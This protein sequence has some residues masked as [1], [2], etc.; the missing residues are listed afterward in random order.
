MTA[1]Q[2]AENVN[3]ILKLPLLTDGLCGTGGVI[4][5]QCEDFVVE[6]IPLYQPCGEGTHI[7]IL[8]EKRGLTT[9]EAAGRLAKA[10][11]RAARDV[12]FAGLKDARSVARQWFSIEHVEPERLRNL[13]I[14]NPRILQIERHRNKLKLGHLAGNRFMIKIRRLDLPLEKAR[15]LAKEVLSILERRGTPNYFGPQRF[16]ST[17]GNHLLGKAVLNDQPETFIDLFLGDIAVADSSAAKRLRHGAEERHALRVLVKSGGDKKAAFRAVNNNLKKFFVSAYQSY[18]FNRVLAARMPAIDKI[19]QGD[20]AYLHRN[21][22]CF[23]VEDA[24]NEQPRCDAFE[25]SPTGPLFGQRMT[26]LTGPAGQIENAILQ[27]EGIDTDDWKGIWYSTPR[28]G[29]RPL[30]F[31]PRNCSVTT[32]ADDAGEYL[33][34]SFELDPGCYATTL[35]REITKKHF[36]EATNAS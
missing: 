31:Q 11:G 22:A 4:K 34:L 27:S 29:R 35:L 10:L 28:G 1:Q 13:Q 32:G 2:G 8:I 20:M 26:R 7:Y 9:S 6:E 18:I 19:I 36:E 16:G 15:S 14:D 24:G 21:G 5:S 17:M 3:E 33:Q 25:I 12:G 30:R 23:H